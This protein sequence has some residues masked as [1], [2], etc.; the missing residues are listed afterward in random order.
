MRERVPV[1]MS[2]LST[3]D[4]GP[5]FSQ[6]APGVLLPLRNTVLLSLAIATKP[7]R[8]AIVPARGLG[9]PP[10]PPAPPPPPPPAPPRPRPPPPPPRLAFWSAKCFVVS[11]RRI[12]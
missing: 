6:F 8:I 10:R 7:L 11:A 12:A 4:T 3:H 9:A 1:S 5:S 2:S